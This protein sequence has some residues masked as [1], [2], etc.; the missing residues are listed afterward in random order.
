MNKVFLTWQDCELKARRMAEEMNR[1]WNIDHFVLYGI[2]RGGIPVAL[3]LQKSLNALGRM[4][5]ITHI[6][7]EANVFVDDIVD[8]GKTKQKYKEKFGD[9]L[10]VSMIESNEQK[11]WYVFPWEI[12]TEDNGPEENIVRL[13]QYIGEDVDREGLIETPQRVIRSY[14][15][16]FGGYRMNPADIMKTFTEGACK[17]MVLL[18]NIELY[19]TCEHHMLPF[20]GRC[21]IAY[22]PNGK[23]IGVSKLARLMEVF[24]RR[25]QIQERIGQQITQCLEEYLRPLGAACIIEAQHFCMTSRGVEKQN[26]VMVTSSLTGVFEKDRDT[27]NEL[28]NLIKD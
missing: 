24:A 23:V 20:H 11:N 27:R 18:K 2:P 4:A 13:M 1:Q 25:M 3:L 12:G 10:F 14:E 6:A 7:E 21:H 8:S 28:M 5:D 17:D 16:L 9:I 15:K 19:S 26:S 22:I